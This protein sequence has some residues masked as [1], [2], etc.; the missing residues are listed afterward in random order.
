MFL[1]PSKN[2]Q[3]RDFFDFD[4]FCETN[5]RKTFLEITDSDKP[6]SETLLGL[7]KKDFSKILFEQNDTL[8]ISRATRILLRRRLEPKLDFFCLKNVSIRQR[9]R[10]NLC[11]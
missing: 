1:N 9:T 2:N 4:R 6:V 7:D 5:S 3:L 11:N 10:E 8:M